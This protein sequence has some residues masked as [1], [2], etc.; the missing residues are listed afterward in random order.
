MV[1]GKALKY[2][3]YKASLEIFFLYFWDRDWVQ[4]G[5]ELNNPQPPKFTDVNHYAQLVST[6]KK[7]IEINLHTM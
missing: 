1:C 6:L 7:I 3:L 2:L 4:T 5:F